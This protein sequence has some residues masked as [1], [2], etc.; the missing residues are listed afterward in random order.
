MNAGTDWGAPWLSLFLELRRQTAWNGRILA[1]SKTD[2][3]TR[4]TAAGYSARR[5]TVGSTREARAAGIQL[6]AAAT[7]AINATTAPYVNGSS[8]VTSYSRLSSPRVAPAAP[9]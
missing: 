5:A 7:A 1:R 4:A 6:A 3:Q 9:V 8:E 2:R